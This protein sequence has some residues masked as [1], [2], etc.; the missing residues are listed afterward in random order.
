MVFPS[1]IFNFKGIHKILQL[2]PHKNGFHELIQPVK[3]EQHFLRLVQGRSWELQSFGSVSAAASVLEKVKEEYS[4]GIFL[5][6]A[7]KEKRSWKVYLNNKEF[8]RN[9]ERGFIGT[10]DLS[11]LQ[12]G[13]WLNDE[14]INGYTGLLAQTIRPEDQKLTLQTWFW[15]SLISNQKTDSEMVK[16]SKSLVST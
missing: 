6:S 8:V 16:I 10:K 15:S 3:D 12:P 1:D 13:T 2:S 4:L 7:E 5:S 11:R 9:I 14:I